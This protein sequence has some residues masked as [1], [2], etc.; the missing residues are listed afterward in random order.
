MPLP[1]KADLI[2]FL[3]SAAGELREI[4]SLLG[5]DAE[6]NRNDVHVIAE[7]AE[8]LAKDIETNGVDSGIMEHVQ[9]FADDVEQVANGVSIR[10]WSLRMKVIAAAVA[11]I[12]QESRIGS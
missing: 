8:A 7:N 11:V 12:L 4:A 5:H 9:H 6:G 1:P 2:S 3:H 10:E